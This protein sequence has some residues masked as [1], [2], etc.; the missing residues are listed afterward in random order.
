M[1]TRDGAPTVVGPFAFSVSVPVVG[2]QSVTLDKTVT[3][4]G[5]T[6]TLDRMVASPSETRVYLRA[7]VALEPTEPYLTAHITGNGYDS[8]NLAITSP[9]ELIGL[10]AAFRA[11]NGEEVVTFNNSLFGRRGRFTLTVESLGAGGRI[12]GPWTFAFV[13]P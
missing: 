7:S 6:L 10:G 1:Q 13:V 2:G 5:I 8:R 3:A 12:A 9:A 11:P 4:G